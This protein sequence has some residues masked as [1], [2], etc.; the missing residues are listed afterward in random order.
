M[1][2][3]YASGNERKGPVTQEA[4]AD[5]VAANEVTDST[6]VWHEG[7]PEWQP[8]AQHRAIV[9]PGL[10]P[11]MPGDGAPMYCMNCG[12]PTPANEIVP[13]GGRRVCASCK[14]I[15][16]QQMREGGLTTNA[17]H[18]YAGFWIRFAAVIID[19]IVVGIASGIVGAV[20]GVALAVSPE[21]P[22]LIFIQLLSGLGAILYEIAMTTIYGATVGKM[23][24]GLK[25]IRAQGGGISPL[26]SVGRYFSKFISAFTLLIGYMMAG[27]DSEKRSLHDRICDT[28][29]IKIR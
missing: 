1:E 19:A 25:V 24:L 13:I 17:Q 21:S 10:P 23:A 26:L 3:F 16:L 22:A 2:W 9:A 28:R 6:L 14:P 12:R 8:F 4:L 15:V 29:V 27:W 5:L 11:A 7:M 20:A 18:R